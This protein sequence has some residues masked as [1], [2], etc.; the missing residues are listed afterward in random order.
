[1]STPHLKIIGELMNNSYG[2]ARKAW[3]SRNVKGYQKEKPGFASSSGAILAPAA[4]LTGPGCSTKWN[5]LK[6]GRV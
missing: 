5:S 4:S 3:Q 2:R 6:V 1:M